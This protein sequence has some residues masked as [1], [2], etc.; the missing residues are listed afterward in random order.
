MTIDQYQPTNI[1]TKT[2][3]VGSG[4]F[5][6][7]WGTQ[8]RNFCRRLA[9]PWYQTHPVIGAQELVG[10]TDNYEAG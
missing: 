6:C 1:S 2:S 9:A 7:V 4:M 10:L 3:L 8:Q 5:T